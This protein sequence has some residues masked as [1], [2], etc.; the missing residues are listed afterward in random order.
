MRYIQRIDGEPFEVEPGTVTRWSCCDCGLVH[1]IAFAI[2]GGKIGVAAQVNRRATAAKRRKR[3]IHA[4]DCAL[5][6]APAL[7]PGPC[8]CGAGSMSGLL[9]P[10]KR[11]EARVGPGMTNPS[12]LNPRR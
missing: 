8:D 7:P 6:N 5:H 4:S 3:V 2:E 10:A 11:T 1:D 12:P 9:G